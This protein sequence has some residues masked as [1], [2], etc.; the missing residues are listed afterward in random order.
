VGGTD[1]TSRDAAHAIT[2]ES[3][4]AAGLASDDGAAGTT[5]APAPA[6]KVATRIS[7]ESMAREKQATAE[8]DRKPPRARTPRGGDSPL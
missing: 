6:K 4:L 7:K 1:A 5:V 3:A 8:A 2:P